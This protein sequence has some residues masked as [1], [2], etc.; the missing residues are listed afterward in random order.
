MAALTE[1]NNFGGIDADRDNL[2]DECFEDHESF[3]AVR[4]FERFLVVGRKGSGKTAIFRKIIKDRRPD[5]F[6]L[7]HTFT[8]YPWHHHNLQMLK[9]VPREECFVQS[10]KY[11]IFI[12]ISKI[13]LNYDQSQPWNERFLDDL[14][15]IENFV[16]DTYGSKDPDLTNL[17]SPTRQI[18][19]KP[20]LGLSLLGV[21]A[22]VEVE[23]IAMEHLPTVAKEVNDNLE[24][25]ILQ[26]LNPDN[27]YY[28]CFDELD[29]G[30]SK[31][32]ANYPLR[33]IGLLK[34]AMQI[35]NLALENHKKLNVVIF[36]RDDIYQFLQFEDKNKLTQGGLVRIEWDTARTKHTL[37][38]LME[39]RFA[40][41][42]SV[43]EEGAWDLVFNE[44]Q[45]MRGNQSKYQHV[46]DRTML[47]PRDMIKFCNEALASYQ[48]NSERT[49]LIEN[50]DITSARSN[51]SQYLVAELDDE[52]QKHLPNHGSY[53]ELL[54]QLEAVQFS[55]EEFQH[56][57]DARPELVPEG[58][59]PRKILGELFEFSVIGFYQS[60]GAGYGGAQYVF[61]YK[62]SR[63]Q[64]N[65][66]AQTYQVHLGLLEAFN[67]KRYR[68]SDSTEE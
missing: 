59:T 39:R 31:D 67:L 6:A 35:N 68:R 25:K 3:E 49:D 61:R 57:C 20:T 5:A 34:A 41:L 10:W 18:H 46:V 64:F 29:L 8:D 50:R 62:D 54:Q 55:I 33:L 24:K 43:G 65:E 28:V 48:T 23:N 21:N 44:V 45:Q 51:Y 15:S 60:G 40:K 53:F 27:L 11:L 7:G 30:F 9:G 66:N 47:R 58:K 56:A 1:I 52:M 13:L 17:F 22:G 4:D 16:L 32:D 14:G 37:R 36:L 38:E 12:T 2:L 19:I 42:L 63:A 26:S